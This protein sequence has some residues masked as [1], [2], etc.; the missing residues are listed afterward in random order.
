[1]DDKNVL[2]GNENPMFAEPFGS[3]APRIKCKRLSKL[4][5]NIPEWLQA[6]IDELLS[7]T[8]AV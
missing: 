4:V 7:F 3:D 6:R 2:K 5:E 1:M 8:A